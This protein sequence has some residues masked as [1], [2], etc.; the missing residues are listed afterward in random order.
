[1]KR[2]L[3]N[4]Y[5]MTAAALAVAL[6]LGSVSATFL[7][8]W[9]KKNQLE[10]SDTASLTHGTLLMTGKTTKQTESIVEYTP[11]PAVTPIVAFGTT[12]YGRST[13]DYVR[14]HVES[15]GKSIVAGINASFFDMATG[16]PLGCEITEGLLRCSR[17]RMVCSIR[18]FYVLTVLYKGV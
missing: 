7:G 1:M 5:K 16:I 11:D 6:L 10:L 3:H 15:K 18:L 17:W 4:L 12:L 2:I 13:I 8:N 14:Q 9:L